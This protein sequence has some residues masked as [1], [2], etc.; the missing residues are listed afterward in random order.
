MLVGKMRRD[1]VFKWAIKEFLP[2]VSLVLNLP[3]NPHVTF[4]TCS[5]NTDIPFAEACVRRG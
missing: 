3:Y 5:P 4:S 1:C 2:L